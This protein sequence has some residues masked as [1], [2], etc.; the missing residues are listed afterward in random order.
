MAKQPRH[1]LVRLGYVASVVT[2][3][4]NHLRKQIESEFFKLGFELYR[5]RAISILYPLLLQPLHP[6]RNLG[7]PHRLQHPDPTSREQ[8]HRRDLADFSPICPKR[9][10]AHDRMIISHELPSSCD[11]PSCKHMIFGS[12]TFFSNLSTAHNEHGAHAHAKHERRSILLSKCSKCS[13]RLL[14]RD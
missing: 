7:L 10:E 5:N 2:L 6:Q 9:S 3:S 4:G 11:R 12:V 8:L 13:M 1:L 14:G